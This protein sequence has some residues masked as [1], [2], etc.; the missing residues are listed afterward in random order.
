MTTPDIWAWHAERA[1][2]HRERIRALN[3]ART[4]REARRVTETPC[5]PNHVA[6][7]V[8]VDLKDQRSD[9]P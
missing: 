2:Y 3:Q 7:V 8:C 5:E 1:I 9:S 6:E 4:A